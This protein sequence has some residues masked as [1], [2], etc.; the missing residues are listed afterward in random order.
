MQTRRPTACFKG[1]IDH[2]ASSIV[3]QVMELRRLA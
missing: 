1:L 3:W 2:L